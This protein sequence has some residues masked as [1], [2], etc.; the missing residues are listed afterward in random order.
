MPSQ[1]TIF[2]YPGCIMSEHGMLRIL[3]S[4]VVNTAV[5]PTSA[6]HTVIFCTATRS[7]PSRWKVLC[8]RSSTMNTRSAGTMLGWW[9]P[10][11]GNVIWVPLFHPGFTSMVST[12]SMGVGCLQGH[13]TYLLFNTQPTFGSNILSTQ[14]LPIFINQFKTSLHKVHVQLLLATHHFICTSQ[15]CPL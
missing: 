1:C 9:L 15:T 11:S 8:G 5:K 12:S 6:S 10:F 14:T 13:A 2:S 7:S 4:Q 3:L